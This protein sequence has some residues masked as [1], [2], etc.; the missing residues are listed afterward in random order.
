MGR[1]EGKGTSLYGALPTFQ[2]LCG[3]PLFIDGGSGRC[4]AVTSLESL[5][6]NSNEQE[7]G[8]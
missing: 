7:L 3:Q 5:M 6:F 1:V 4:A 8:N 2:S